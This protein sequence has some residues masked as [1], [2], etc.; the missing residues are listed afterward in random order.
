MLGKER[1]RIW[2]AAV[3]LYRA[4]EQWWLTPEEDALLTQANQG[5]QSSDAWEVD[6]L[7][8]LQ[9][10]SICTISELLNK[11]IA[12]ELQ[13]QGKAEQMRVGSI[14]RRNGWKKAPLQK[15]IDGKPQWYWEKVVTGGDEVVTEVVT[16]LNPL[17]AT[18]SEQVSPPVTTFSSNFSQNTNDVVEA[19]E[20]NNSK[21]GES[22]ENR[23]S[24][25]CSQTSESFSEQGL[26]GVTTSAS[27]PRSIIELSAQI[28]NNPIAPLEVTG[29]PA[30]PTA[31]PLAPRVN[32]KSGDRVKVSAQYP[33]AQEYID[34]RATVVKVWPDGVCRIALDREITVIGGKPTKQFNLDGRYLVSESAAESNLN[35]EELELVNLMRFAIS[36][37]DPL[38]TDAVKKCL[39]ET[40]DKGLANRQKVWFALT[41]SE[42]TVFKAL[43][44]K[45]VAQP[46]PEQP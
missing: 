44:T 40:C 19:D 18:I 8:Y 25:T 46:Q 16:P 13:H 22:L 11:A 38:V 6:I 35:E 37:S 10:K 31:P 23:G 4:G 1:D 41:A 30:E 12:I 14:L 20:T 24:D 45:L 27:L 5:W 28:T 21:S 17:S 9:T 2:A 42:Q 15:R 34:E 39:R 43:L 29:E 3:Q 26:E 33:G 36:Q 7:S 32:W